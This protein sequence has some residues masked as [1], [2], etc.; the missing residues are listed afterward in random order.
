MLDAEPGGRRDARARIGLEDVVIR[1]V[2]DGV[3][4]DL[5][6]RGERPPGD[7]LDLLHRGQHESGVV[8]VVRVGRLEVRSPGAE[9]AIGKDLDGPKGEEVIGAGAD[10][11]AADRLVERLRVRGPVGVHADLQ[12]AGARQA[13]VDVRHPRGDAHLVDR[14]E[15]LREQELLR[16]EDGLL[17]L[18]LRRRRDCPCDQL[19]GVV[20]EDARGLS[21][22]VA[23]NTSSGWIRRVPGDL[24][25]TQGLGVRPC[26]VS[27]HA[28]NEDGRVRCNGVE[29]RPGGELLVRVQVLV[30]AA[31]LDPGTGRDLREDRP[32]ALGAVRGGTAAPEVDPDQREPE[33]DDVTVGIGQGGHDDGARGAVG[34]LDPID[35]AALR[36][37]R[38]RF[39]LGRPGDHRGWP[40]RPGLNGGHRGT[41]SEQDDEREP[42]GRAACTG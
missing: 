17:D 33:A 10:R 23:K 22:G 26:G 7:G 37:D 4:G 34:V 24:G 39:A 28:A 35:P 1:R 2:A 20:D 41:A 11:T 9:R 19:L 6:S 16:T 30:P 25:A 12:L 36:R 31:A 8:R 32:D 13:Q 27:V 21:R 5:E 29:R 38:H 42:H 3:G 14:G 18:E 40:S 15:P